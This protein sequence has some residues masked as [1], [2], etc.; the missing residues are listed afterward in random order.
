MQPVGELDQQH[1]HVVGNR[2]QELAQ[3]FG[4]L[5]LFGDEVELLELGQPLDQRANIGPEH[6]VDLGA[7]R[8]G[9]LDGVVQ[10]CGRDRG[11]IELEIGENRSDLE[12][13]GKIGVAG[14]PR[15]LAMRLHGIDVGAVEQRL[16]GIRVVALDA[17][18]Q[19]VLPHHLRLV[20]LPGYCKTLKDLRVRSEA[21]IERCPNP[22]L[23]LHARQV[24]RRARH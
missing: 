15:L 9:V 2:Q 17:L 22:G 23:V 12:R 14:G 4:L 7:G 20:R 19:V 13:M 3:I 5:G 21:A 11:I 18:D 1:A 6:L 24:A 10:Q 8:R 16:A